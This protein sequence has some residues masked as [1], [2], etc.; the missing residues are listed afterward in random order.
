MPP[1][2]T[3]STMGVMNMNPLIG[4][5]TL[6]GDKHKMLKEAQGQVLS[7]V[8]ELDNMKPA[9]E[10]IELVDELNPVARKWRD[11]VR[12]M[13]HNIENRIDELMGN[14]EG[15][16]K[17]TSSLGLKRL[18][19][20][21]QIAAEIEQLKNLAMRANDERVKN[22]ID[23]YIHSSS[24]F[25]AADPEM[26]VIYKKATREELVS[27]LADNEEELKVVSI[28]GFG[29]LGKTTLAKEVYDEIGRK[30]IYKAFVSVSRNPDM[31][32]LL[33][34]LQLQ[35][36]MDSEVA[37]SAGEVIEGSTSCA[38]EVIEDESSPPWKMQ[39]NI[40]QLREY[41]SHKRYIIV[42]D[43]LWD[44]LACNTISSIFANDDG[45]E[46]IATMH[47]LESFKVSRLSLQSSGAGDKIPAGTIAN[48][49]LLVRSLALF[50]ESTSILLSC[51]YVRVLIIEIPLGYQDTDKITDLTVIN[52]LLKLRYLKVSAQKRIKLLEIRGLEH[53]ETLELDCM[54]Q[55]RDR[56]YIA[57]LPHLSR[58][59]LPKHCRVLP[60]GIGNMEALH[61]LHWFD[62]G[63]QT[64]KDITA[65]GKLTRLTYLR[66][67]NHTMC[68][69]ATEDAD[70]LASSIG[71]LTHLR[72]LHIDGWNESEEDQLMNSL[73]LPRHLELKV[74]DLTNCL[75]TRLPKW[76]GDLC[77]LC[78]LNLRVWKIS[79]DEVRV[80]GNLPSLVDLYLWA[81]CFAGPGRAIV[82]GRGSFPALQHLELRSRDDVTACLEFE[83]GAMTE[84]QELTLRF[85]GQHWGGATPAGM[86]H[87]LRL[88]QI[89]LHK[90]PVQDHISAAKS[91]F[92]NAT[93]VHPN[94]PS[95]TISG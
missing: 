64:S 50:G 1:T 95:F 68:P 13:S 72:Y 29:G 23:D 66:I 76:I 21:H 61:T 33:N 27:C 60:E 54:D 51:K 38:G 43:D 71:K 36:G 57:H 10:K 30:F 79:P 63:N 92:S 37:S 70:A 91:A 17:K 4:K 49:L 81:V 9:V 58:L 24:R 7:L 90:F 19:K 42:I 82:A 65:L 39:H 85:D 80:L 45:F 2:N 78:R 84:L 86:E 28:L 5:L 67:S 75:I 16:I 77:G 34:S 40:A 25:G 18:G 15:F 47:D 69:L 35:L 44:Q 56:P 12:E 94:L 55:L 93:Q 87:L 62:V 73:S 83:A 53:L 22:K 14:H 89:R 32:R 8:Y 31:T 26:S 59:I 41:L 11:D 20:R 74:L 46:D 48:G 6:M 3:S 88:Q 52:H